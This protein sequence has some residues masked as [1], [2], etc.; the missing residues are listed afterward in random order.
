MTCTV[1]GF[2]EKLLELRS[3]VDAFI[4][5]ELAKLNAPEWVEIKWT[6]VERLQRTGASVRHK[7]RGSAD[8]NFIDREPRSYDGI[9]S[10]GN[11][12][13][14]V[15]LKT[16][17]DGVALYE[18]DWVEVSAADLAFLDHSKVHTQ[19]RKGPENIWTDRLWGGILPI[20][21]QLQADRK[22][23]PTGYEPTKL[24]PNVIEWDHEH[25]S[26]PCLFSP[27]VPPRKMSAG[28]WHIVATRTEASEPQQDEP[29]KPEPTRK[30]VTMTADEFLRQLVSAPNMVRFAS[31]RGGEGRFYLYR[32]DSGLFRSVH[33]FGSDVRVDLCHFFQVGPYEVGEIETKPVEPTWLPCTREEAESHPGESEI[34]WG[35]KNQWAS[36]TNTMTS[37]GPVIEFHRSVLRLSERPEYRTRAE[38]D[39]WVKVP[40][41]DAEEL[42]NNGATV[43]H[44][45]VDGMASWVGSALVYWPVKPPLFKFRADR[46]TL[47]PGYVLGVGFVEP[48]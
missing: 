34:T 45:P 11:V 48:K 38:V 36:I 22:T 1:T 2:V 35:T 18:P 12:T 24:T 42:R 47:P 13:Y 16:V 27:L 29:T 40:W 37:L 39:K 7:K 6:E 30:T 44:V 9:C 4:A 3:K 41:G 17:P 46:T 43:E 10:N 26:T 14:Q 19:V 28:K 21:H 23:F 5:A 20:P 33:A 15:D 31:Y 25:V 8:D 32:I